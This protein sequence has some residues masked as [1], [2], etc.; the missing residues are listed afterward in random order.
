[1]SIEMNIGLV[2]GLLTLILF[3]AFMTLWALAWNKNRQADFEQIARLPLE[4]QDPSQDLP[5]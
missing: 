4:D 1:M 3:L 2:R 5:R